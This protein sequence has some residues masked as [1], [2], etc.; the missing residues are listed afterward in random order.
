M[1]PS[2]ARETRAA[3]A[4]IRASIDSS[5]GAPVGSNVDISSLAPCCRERLLGDSST[6]TDDPATCKRRPTLG[7]GATV[8]LTID[9]TQRELRY[10]APLICFLA[11]ARDQTLSLAD[12]EPSVPPP[13]G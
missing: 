2:W 9:R 7:G 13:R 5:V 10:I 12:P 8:F 3:V 4:S 6:P 1:V 11:P